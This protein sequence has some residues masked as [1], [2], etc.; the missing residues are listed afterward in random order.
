M[1]IARSGDVTR[2]RG[3]SDAIGA[4]RPS[5][6]ALH[7][8]TRSRRLP[9]QQLACLVGLVGS[10]APARKPATTSFPRFVRSGTVGSRDG[11]LRTRAHSIPLRPAVPVQHR[12]RRTRPSLRGLLAADSA[13]S[14]ARPSSQARVRLLRIVFQ[15]ADHSA[16]RHAHFLCAVGARMTTGPVGSRDG[17]DQST[18]HLTP[19]DAFRLWA[20]R[21][22]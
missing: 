21:P 22:I 18:M 20:R 9:G 19:V 3:T 2:R 11:N 17:H 1:T 13:G 12:G 4:P 15:Q 16:V 8:D 14:L 5:P 10:P 7:S 6:L